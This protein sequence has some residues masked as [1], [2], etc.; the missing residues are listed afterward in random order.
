MTV[1]VIAPGGFD[2]AAYHVTTRPGQMDKQ[3]AGILVGR[4]GQP[5]E[6]AALVSFLVSEQASYLTGATI[7]LNGGSRMA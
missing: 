1:N 3:I 4:L 6:F 2:T 5:A 7:D